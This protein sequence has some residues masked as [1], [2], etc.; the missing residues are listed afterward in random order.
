MSRFITKEFPLLYVYNPQRVFLQMHP[1]VLV[2]LG[3]A[4]GRRTERM[5][6]IPIIDLKIKLVELRFILFSQNGDHFQGA[7]LKIML[8]G[9]FKGMINF[10]DIREYLDPQTPWDNTIL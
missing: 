4:G 3:E 8:P 10:F 9:L 7:H 2:T 1:H 5:L 6:L